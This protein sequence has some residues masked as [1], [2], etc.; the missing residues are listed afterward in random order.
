MNQKERR[1]RERRFRLITTRASVRDL[2]FF[3][4]ATSGEKRR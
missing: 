1:K 4:Q 2:F 3:D